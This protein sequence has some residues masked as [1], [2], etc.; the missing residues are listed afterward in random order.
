M[1]SPYRHTLAIVKYLP[2]DVFDLTV[3]SLSSP[4]GE[5]ET[6]L[7]DLGANWLV[8][9]FRPTGRTLRHV[10][11]S[12]RKQH[13]IEECG[14]F[15]IQHTLD[16]TTWPF[17]AMLARLHRRHFITHQRN[18]NEGGHETALKIKLRL[19]TRV[20][21]NSEAVQGFLLSVGVPQQRCRLIH[22]GIDLENIPYGLIPDTSS[23]QNIL[24]VGHLERRK[25]IEDAVCAIE[26]VRR[27][28]PAVRLLVAGRTHDREY[29]HELDA[30]VARLGLQQHVEFL[31]PQIE[32][33]ELMRSAVALVHCAESEAFGWV[34]VEAMSVG[35]P[36]IAAD[37]GGP[38][39]I[40]E[41]NRT[42]FLVPVSDVDRYAE[43]LR[44]VLSQPVLATSVAENARLAVERQFSAKAM[45]EQIAQVY[46]EV[47]E[48]QIPT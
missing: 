21:A 27:D 39:K 37:T 34:I 5:E 46:R 25:R 1:Q 43:V 22:N 47:V 35:L 19:S 38:A 40:I 23:R 33:L 11:R 45:V 26:A 42:G 6:E 41:N 8:A 15:D 12:L 29:Y 17:E 32:V 16:Y 4:N 2:Q 31:G 44:T 18:L 36:V 14:P 9:P 30:L 48:R 24:C 13:L 7:R 3:C 28:F 10:V 20:I